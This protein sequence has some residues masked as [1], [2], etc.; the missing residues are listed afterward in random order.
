[1]IL[2][3]SRDEWDTVCQGGLTWGNHQDSW[4]TV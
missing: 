1:M 4:E 2:G 3:E